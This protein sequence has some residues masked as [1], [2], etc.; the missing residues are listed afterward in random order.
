MSETILVRF[1][2]LSGGQVDARLLP[3]VPL[4]GSTVAFP[5]GQTMVV[6]RQDWVLRDDDSA[7]VVATV[8]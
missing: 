8:R 4:P 1:R 2:T 5:T 7:Y 3:C 6:V